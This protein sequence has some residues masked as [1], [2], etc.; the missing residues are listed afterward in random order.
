MLPVILIA[1]PIQIKKIDISKGLSNNFIQGITQDREGFIWIGTESGLNR[2]DGNSFKNFYHSDINPHTIISNELNDVVADKNYDIIWIATERSGLSSYNYK[3]NTFRTFQ[4]DP[5]DQNSISSHGIM[6]LNTESSGNLW[7]STYEKG[8]ELLNTKTFK[9]DRFNE[10]TVKGL[11]SNYTRCA[12]DDHH[13]NLY[14][15]HLFAGL[16]VVSIQHKT[17]LHFMPDANDPKSLPAQQVFDILIDSKK[18]V[19]LATENGLALYHPDKKNF[20]VFRSSPHPG[21]LASSFITSLR[22]INN[23]IWIGTV[24]GISIL[25][26]QYGI[27]DNPEKVIF[28][29]IKSSQNP[30]DLSH[31]IINT[32][33]QDNFNNIW[34]GTVGGGIDFISNKA[35]F[36]KTITYSPFAHYPD[37]LSNRCVLGMDFDA[38]GNLWMGTDG[39]GIDIFNN[40][41][42]IN[43][44][45][46]ANTV[47]TDDKIISILKDTKN[48]MWLGASDGTVMYYNSDSQKFTSIPR[49]DKKDNHINGFYQDS[50]Q[51]LWIAA[52]NGLLKYNMVSGKKDIF[53]EQ[54]SPL[55]YVVI[56]SV[57]GDRNE[58]IWAGS[59]G[60]GLLVI[61]QDLKM[62]RYFPVNKGFY[63]INYIYRDSNNRMW[64]CTRQNLHLFEN[65]EDTHFSTYGLKDGLA[66]NYIRAIIEGDNADSFW[67]STDRGISNLNVKTGEIKNFGPKDGIPLGNFMNGA[68]AKSKDGIIYFG[69]ENG[70][71]YF[72]SRESLPNFEIPKVA[73]T[74]LAII[75]KVN[76]FTTDFSDIPVAE[77]IQLN[78]NQSTISITLNV[79][80]YSLNDMVEFS[81]QMKGLDDGWYNLH[82]EKSVVFRNLRPGKYVFSARARLRNQ[83]WSYPDTNITLIIHPPFWLSW[84]AMFIYALIVLYI[85]W[86]IIRFYKNKVALENSLLYEKKSHEQEQEFNEERMR[87][88]TN[89]THEIRT[90]LTM[91]VG[92]LEDLKSRQNLDTDLSKKLN[93]I[94]RN[95]NRLLDLINQILEFRKTET[96]NRKLKITSG[97][98]ANLIQEI[99]LKYQDLNTKKDV[100][101]QIEIPKEEKQMYFDSEVITIILDNLISNALKY[102]PKGVIELKLQYKEN[103][104]D[105]LTEITLKD[106]GLGIPADEL[107]YIFDRY[108]RANAKHQIAGTGIGLSLVK[109]LVELHQGNIRVESHI[110]SGTIFTFTLLTNNTYPNALHVA[111]LQDSEKTVHVDDE[112]EDELLASKSAGQIM[113]VIDDN[114]EIR[115]Y[116][117]DCFVDKFEVLVAENGLDG[118]KIAQ[119]RTPDIIISDVM[120]PLMDGIEL[121]K[122]IKQDIKTSHIPV[123]LLTAKDT[124][125][126]KT[127]GYSIGADSYITKP[128][129]S[130]LLQ[131][132]VANILELRRKLS[133]IIVAPNND[134]KQLLNES[135]NKLDQEFLEK[136]DALIEMNLET[137]QISIS[138]IA[139]QLHMSHSTLYRKIKSI[140]GLTTNEYVRKKRIHTAEK[141]LITG[142]YRINEIMYMVGINSKNYFRECFKEEFGMNPKEYLE[143][144]RAQE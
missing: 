82:D 52:E 74:N 120:M 129:S 70:V 28:R 35:S 42:K 36:F 68:V 100:Y 11:G 143:S 91:I 15:G 46:R 102:T 87:F 20:T 136:V 29:N 49:F 84:W 132:R 138:N 115:Q 125:Q 58:N 1:N 47:L 134:K 32:I 130:N 79:L 140:T 66:N 80:D 6:R 3:T 23:E 76:S 105:E 98:I 121:C 93:S 9:F 41:K 88:F 113:L 67:I 17:A 61:S 117:S 30:N 123:I 101:L 107:P 75:D 103:S 104:H 128:F 51:N 10:N 65:C 45:T 114:D 14:I 25:E 110:N 39:G 33:I 31:P 53:T 135:L 119:D 122:Q 72:N 133:S 96:R 89:I 62:V 106:P 81:Y 90:P 97:S 109:N 141:L 137:E 77:S 92:P 118:L 71:C 38:A 27:Q 24:N 111:A 16:S 144:I 131:T 7:I 34:I 12:A 5:N 26:E 4:H 18:R 21:S 8:V 95:A 73:I 44:F 124:I 37:K 13:G 60:D 56:R 69:S 99:G 54:N 83:V 94:S 57:A 55:R 2:F 64:V 116:I 22:E 86:Q 85:V 43:N 139:F 112:E 40:G 63:G 59:L 142:K 50:Y 108:Y 126:D 19:W 48:N 78:Y 127:E